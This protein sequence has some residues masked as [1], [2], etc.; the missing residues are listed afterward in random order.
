MTR[1]PLPAHPS[2]SAQPAT[3]SPSSLS[4]VAGAISG[5]AGQAVGHPLDTLNIH[6]QAGRSTEH[7]RFW[8]LWRGASVP[9]MTVGAINSL[10]LGVFEN[11]RRALWPHESPTPLPVL[12]AAGTSCGLAVSVVTCPLSRVK[13]LQQLTGT[14]FF[15]GVQRCLESRSLFRA[16]PTAVV[17]LLTLSLLTLSLLLLSL[18]LL[19][20]LLLTLLTLALLLRTLLSSTLTL[21]LTLTSYGRVRV[22]ATW[23][24]TRCSSVHSS[25][26]PRAVDTCVPG[27][28]Y[29]TL[30]PRAPAPRL[31]YVRR[32][33]TSLGRAACTA[34][35]G[36]PQEASD[37]A[38]PLWS[39]LLAGGGANV[40]PPYA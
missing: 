1:R 18:L 36:T 39:R 28:P 14:R 24:S 9:V 11:V 23:C 25:Q 6:A 7:L 21:T 22:G 34:H 10:A 31:P 27:P 37:R 15:V 33:R 29:C 30:G 2:S 17:S 8:S 38:L 32:A 3:L 13:I 16:Y 12:A 35:R 26:L 19:I 5:A 4:F 20:L 40:R